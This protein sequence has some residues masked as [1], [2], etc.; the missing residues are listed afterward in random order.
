MARTIGAW[1][2]G[3]AT[4][5]ALAASG[6]RHDR[7]V[8]LHVYL[9]L[10]G[11][12]QLVVLG[13]F[14]ERVRLDHLLTWPYAIGLGALSASAVVG[15]VG[16]GRRRPDLR[17]PSGG[18]TWWMR[19]IVIGLAGFTAFLAV[20]TLRAGPGGQ[21]AYGGVVPETLSLFSIRAFSAFLFAISAASWS[22]LLARNP[23]PMWELDRGGFVLST[24]IL[25]AA[26]LHL[27]AFDFG[28][29]AGGAVYIGAYALAS[30][31]FAIVWALPRWRPDLFAADPP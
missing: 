11:P 3:T 31:L 29:R 26:V 9:W 8:G 22:M 2:I 28:A 6:S 1:A 15:L 10:F 25:V 16:W 4:I 5:A 17:G 20:G 13:A 24:M 19:V 27:G 18:V 7:L 14:A 21:T 12:L 30:I 23:R